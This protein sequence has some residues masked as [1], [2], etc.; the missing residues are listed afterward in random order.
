MI[1]YLRAISLCFASAIG[2]VFVLADTGHSAKPASASHHL[3]KPAVSATPVNTYGQLPLA[4]ESNSGQTDPRVKFIAR[5]SGY[6]VFITSA[7]MV[8]RLD[9]GITPVSRFG[10]GGRQAALHGAAVDGQTLVRIKLEGINQAAEL[11]GQDE[12]PG[13]AN[14]F[15]GNDPK[16]WRTNIPTYARVNYHNVY[17]G[18]DLSFHANQGQFEYDFIVAP[19]A[20]SSKIRL[21][22][23]GVEQLE[24]NHQGDLVLHTRLGNVLQ[25]RPFVY[26][27]I[28]GSRKEIACNYVLAGSKSVGFQVGD[29]D[30]AEPLVIDPVFVYSTLLGGS[31]GAVVEA[32]AA[33]NSGAAY[34]TGFTGSVDFPTVNPVQPAL[35]VNQDIFIAKLNSS[36]SALL[37]STY[38]GGSNEEFAFSIAVDPAG[39]AYVTGDTDSPDFPTVNAFQQNPTGMFVAK[40]S[41]AGSSLLY[42]TYLGGGGNEFSQGIAVDNAGSVYVTGGTT[43][44]NFPTTVNAFQTTLQGIQSA[45]VTKFNPNGT[46]LVYSTFLGGTGGAF[47]QGLAIDPQGNAYVTGDVF[48]PDFPTV[49][50][51]QP[52]FGGIQDAFVAKLD[53]TGSNLVFST[54]LGGSQRDDGNSVAVDALGNVYVT[55]QSESPDFPA[56]NALQQSCF[57]TYVTKLTPNGS[58]VVYSTCFG[59]HGETVATGIRV[60]TDGNVYL[61]GVTS[62][63]DLPVVNAIQ[64]VFAG[65]NDAYAAKLSPS[66]SEFLF[67]TYLGG[68]GDDVGRGMT[69]DGSGNIYVVGQTH[70]SGP[71][72]FPLANAFQSTSSDGAD[73]GFISK[74][75]TPA[76]TT[77][78][79]GQTVTISAPKTASGPDITASLTNNT[80]GSPA[81]T[82]TVD[83]FL[84]D[85]AS[86]GAIDV[87][88]GFLDLRIAGADAADRATANFYYSS[89]ITGLVE[90]ELQLL[91]FNGVTWLPVRSSGN[92]DPLKNITDNLD[93][94]VSGG[95]FTAV[96]DNTSTP[97]VTEL[98]GTLFSPSL[99][100][101]DGGIAL[102]QSEV[103]G[104]TL[105]K[106]RK[107]D[108]SRKLEA[109]NGKL[110]QNKAKQAADK[111][112]DFIKDVNDLVRKGDLTQGQAQP[113]L[114]L[115]NA[116]LA[117]LGS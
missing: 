49:N 67:L 48:A 83:E 58:A 32:I 25:K 113:L 2:V 38:L 86:V 107:D 62:A 98:T 23:E 52:A 8:L 114:D 75:T 44:A 16:K 72:D 43:S 29:F 24:M 20:D 57:G 34:I 42:S 111:I 30:P 88:G 112:Q 96:F 64:P 51:L 31:S 74:I 9:K 68:S 26:Q 45:F 99:T 54:Y 19:G 108:L 93:N 81:V 102:L 103:A 97:R 76:I 82:M 46:T 66:G 40:L 115:A 71:S 14:Y 92:T 84:A 85:P 13:K 106:D 65:P 105:K 87:G 100:P 3:R 15:I 90:S 35:N 80:P 94:T 61:G 95:R 21:S 78:P 4:F 116:I 69:I 27:Q 56:I 12:L 1:C 101:R 110:N 6:T 7:E 18:A 17:P 79:P 63:P 60:D 70:S 36:G 55:G 5:G 22:F 50:A 41:P 109:A 104:L 28:K 37:Y 10:F 33:D 53:P 89:S 117:Q 11:Q 59:G 77:V 47:A 73:F 91:Y 39:N